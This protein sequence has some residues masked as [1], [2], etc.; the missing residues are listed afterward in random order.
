MRLRLLHFLRQFPLCR[1]TRV[2]QRPRQIQ[3][4][5][6]E[7]GLRMQKLCFRRSMFSCLVQRPQ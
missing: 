7:G 1:N 2:K 3:I 6:I 5:F 4:S